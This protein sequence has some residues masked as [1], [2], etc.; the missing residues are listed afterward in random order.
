MDFVTAKIALGG[1]P[2]HVMCRGAERPVSW[3]EI[4]VLQSLHGEAN[5]FDCDFVRSEPSTAQMEKMRLLGI[6]G[7][8]AIDVV[9]PGAR[10]MMEMDFP[11]DRDPVA[12]KRPERRLIADIQRS[13][14]AQ[15]LSDYNSGFDPG[16]SDRPI[17]T[18]PAPSPA[19]GKRA[20]TN[21]EV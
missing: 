21:A 6:Y 10:P 15:K 18:P 20:S 5:V 16:G 13:D 9:Y 12:E 19:K 11:G 14:P 17:E 2:A 4:R 8:D 1:D 3:P 7:K